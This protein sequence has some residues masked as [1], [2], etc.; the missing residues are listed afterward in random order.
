MP[1]VKISVSSE[2]IAIPNLL[3]EAGLVLSTSE[4]MRMIKQGAVKINGEK[5]PQNGFI[6]PEK[7]SIT[8]VCQVGK[9]KFAKVILVKNQE[10][11]T[12]EA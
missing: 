8:I 7:S 10:K 6:N 11:K 12:L 5:I 2:G 4:A 3:K 1:E 9:R